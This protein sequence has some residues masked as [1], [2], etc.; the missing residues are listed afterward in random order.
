[1]TIF[2]NEDYKLK[3]TKGYERMKTKKVAI[4][5]TVR[6]CAKA[7]I[8]NISVIE[9]LRKCFIESYVV[10]VENDSRDNTKNILNTWSKD[11]K[12]V[13]VLS[14]D[15]GVPT[16]P[17]KCPDGA[18][19]F[20]SVHRIGLMAKYR[21]QYLDLLEENPE[22]DYVIVV[23]L[24]IHAISL[25]GIANT[26]GQPVQWHAVSSNGRNI[27]RKDLYII[28]HFWRG[29][30]YFDTYAFRELGDERP[31]TEEMMSAYQMLLKPLKKGMPMIRV[32]S[33]FGGLAVY[34]YNAIKDIRYGCQKNNDNKVA[35][36]SEHVFFHKE[37]AQNSYD[38]IYLNPSQ[39]V[40]YDTYTNY[41]K[42]SPTKLIQKIIS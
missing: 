8:R 17:K 36:E 16:I 12:K 22:V 4:C 25:D 28:F 35:A 29:H 6:D 11:S 1:M 34:Q 38:L 15:L 13:Y 7:L 18:N 23:D 27:F 26:F 41:I 5:S 42:T 2:R 32:A 21:N 40:H 31:Q 9:K 39:I 10:I 3:V 37:M 30:I 19:P 14:E 33:S 24:D 20:F